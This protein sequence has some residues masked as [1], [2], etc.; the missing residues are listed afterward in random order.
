MSLNSVTLI[1]YLGKDPDLRT[2]KNGTSIANFSLATSSKKKGQDGS[3]QDET[4][5]HRCTCFDKQADFA[6]KYLTKGRLVCVQGSIK[7]SKYTDKNGVERVSYDIICNTVQ[8]LGRGDD[9]GQARPQASNTNRTQ[10]ST[11]AR[12]QSAPDDAGF[13]DGVDDDI[14]F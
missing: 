3:W 9:A 5:W 8:A 4:E 11:Q 13:G 14:P 12:T 7:S 2:A 6:A 1:G 10:S